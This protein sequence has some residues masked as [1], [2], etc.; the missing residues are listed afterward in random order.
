MNGFTRLALVACFKWKKF[1]RYVAA[2]IEPTP[3][4]VLVGF[5]HES[6]AS[7]SGG[8]PLFPAKGSRSI[9]TNTIH[10]VP[11]PPRLQPPRISRTAIAIRKREKNTTELTAAAW[12]SFN[13]RLLTAP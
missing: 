12:A 6:L 10:V 11:G 9:P 8:T 13:P 5:C 1:Q 2:S 3:G 4:Y 7:I